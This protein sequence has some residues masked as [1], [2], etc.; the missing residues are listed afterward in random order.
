MRSPL[1]PIITYDERQ[2]HPSTVKDLAFRFIFWKGRRVMQVRIRPTSRIQFRTW[3]PRGAHHDVYKPSLYPVDRSADPKPIWLANC[4][5]WAPERVVCR[6][7]SMTNLARRVGHKM[8]CTL[9]TAPARMDVWTPANPVHIPGDVV[10]GILKYSNSFIK[11]L[12]LRMESHRLGVL[13]LRLRQPFD[14]V[15]GSLSLPSAAR[16]SVVKT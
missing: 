12:L 4:V 14:W 15:A 1:K 7:C 10:Q 11:R 5:A 13:H 3:N 8:F 9:V 6:V 16:Q 2:K